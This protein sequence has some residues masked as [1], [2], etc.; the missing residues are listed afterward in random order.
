MNHEI[1]T[2][3]ETKS[4]PLNWLCYPD[5]AAEY[6]ITLKETLYYL[7]VTLY[8][9][10]SLAPFGSLT[11]CHYLC[12]DMWALLYRS[13]L[14]H[15]FC[16]LNCARENLHYTISHLI[17]Y[18]GFLGRG[19]LNYDRNVLLLTTIS[20]NSPMGFSFLN[21]HATLCSEIPILFKEKKAQN[22]SGV[23]LLF[24]QKII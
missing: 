23:I 2:W 7:A 14:A 16:I 5:A 13:C 21:I 24:L 10:V 8:S 18:I 19:E 12:V 11:S 3:A 17:Y 1:T 4:W 9:P 6:V 22:R 20:P 15:I